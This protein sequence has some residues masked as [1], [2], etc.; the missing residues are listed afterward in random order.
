MRDLFHSFNLP[1]TKLHKR[2]C[3]G[4]KQSFIGENG[5]AATL[6]SGIFELDSILQKSTDNIF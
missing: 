3:F 5:M 4:T 2:L 1:N 6:K